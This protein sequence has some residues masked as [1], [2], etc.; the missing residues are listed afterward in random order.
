[1]QGD[2]KMWHS[3]KSVIR[4]HSKNGTKMAWAMIN[5]ISGW[6]RIKPTCVDGVA[7]ILL[8]LSSAKANGRNVDV[9]I[10][11][12]QIEQATLR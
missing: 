8:I 5:G 9:Y 4:T 6:L 7:N 1:M 11:G 3:N 12:D 10:N 2:K